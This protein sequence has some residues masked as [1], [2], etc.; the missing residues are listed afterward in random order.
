MVY[1]DPVKR[2]KYFKEYQEKNKEKL[3][4]RSVEWAKNNPE[5]RKEIAKKYRENNPEI[6]KQY[7]LQRNGWTVDNYKFYISK[8]E[9]SCA[10]CGEL[11]KVPQA[12]HNH[13]TG[14]PRKLLCITCN[15][16]LGSFKDN[17][18][19]LRKAAQYIEDQDSMEKAA[20]ELAI[21]LSVVRPTQEIQNV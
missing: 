9:G 15:T 21:I 1:K 3:S 5:R 16:G 18:I 19:I 2:K 14:M 4:H 11:M 6:S 12:D 10:I 13:K 20:L 7:V 17:P 8:Q